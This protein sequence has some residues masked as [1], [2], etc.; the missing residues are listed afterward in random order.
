[1]AVWGSEMGSR[2]AQ[3]ALLGS[4]GLD[5]GGGARGEGPSSAVQSTGRL[6]CCCNRLV[7]LLSRGCESAAGGRAKSLLIGDD[8]AC[9]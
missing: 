7:P 3:R 2:G 9:C 1:M 4:S 6:G 5:G 8:D